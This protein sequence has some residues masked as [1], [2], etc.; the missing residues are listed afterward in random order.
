MKAI[1]PGAAGRQA[2]AETPDRRLRLA[3]LLLWA[4]LLGLIFYLIDGDKP[5]SGGIAE[6]LAENRPLRAIDYARTYRWWISLGGATLSALLLATLRHWI[7]SPRAAECPELHY[8][9][10][11]GS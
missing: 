5:W 8:V 10:R 3:R 1:R 2:G 4:S 9:A 6:R 11:R 7:G